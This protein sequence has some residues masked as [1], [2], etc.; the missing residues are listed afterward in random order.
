MENRMFKLMSPSGVPIK[1]TPGHFSTGH[2]HINYYVDTTTL[3]ARQ[4]EAEDAA[5]SL[6]AMYV[7]N[8][9]V[10][11]IVC[12][13]GTEVIGAFLAEELTRAGVMSMNAHKT[14]YVVPPEYNSN[15]QLFFRDNILPMINGK[16]VIVLLADVS[17][18]RTSA[19]CVEGIQYYGGIVQGVCALFSAVEE[20]AGF[21][22][23]AV[24]TKKELPDYR[25]YA[26]T[27]C[28]F[29]KQNLPLDALVN[30]FGYS[31]F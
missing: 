21:R 9:I 12:I 22:V 15:G 2:S 5:R 13:E 3:K 27:D 7:H 8:T 16:N 30:S 10:D 26:S 23:N 31:K 20:V 6:A 11:T 17:T 4:S 14:I 1:I 29:C 24:F 19:R 28:P 18:G 25:A